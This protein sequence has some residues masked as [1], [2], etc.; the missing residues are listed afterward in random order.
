MIKIT[1]QLSY[2][3]TD[4]AHSQ[5][6]AHGVLRQIANDAICGTFAE[7][8]RLWAGKFEKPLNELSYY[9]LVQIGSHLF[10]FDLFIDESLFAV[11]PAGFQHLIGVLAGDLFKPR[12]TISKVELPE[13]MQM[14]AKSLFRQNKAYSI[15][16]IRKAFALQD[17]EPLLAFSVKPRNGLRFDV[18]QDITLEVL[19][20]GFHI[21]ELDTR[22][23]NLQPKE[24]ALLVDLS[25]RASEISKKRI[26]RFSPNLS[27]PSHL[28]VDIASQFVNAVDNGPAVIK[29]DGGL[30]GIS[31][32]QAIR[33]AFSNAAG[34][35]QRSPIITCYPLLRLQLKD[36]ISDNLLVDTLTL[37]GADIVYIGARPS[38]PSSPRELDAADP[39]S[40]KNSVIRYHKFIDRNESMPTV[41]GGIQVNQLHA[42]YELLG[43]NAAFFVGGAVSLHKD[44][45]AKGASL[46]VQI[47][48]QAVNL[49]KKW[50]NRAHYTDLGSRLIK[51]CENKYDARF[52]YISPKDLFAKYPGLTGWFTRS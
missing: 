37:S 30:D 4:D 18:L 16:E 36:K 41:A 32:C 9:E 45:V 26:T 3:P 12:V 44:G 46:C 48:N 39:G 13:S 15:S 27:V 5:N 19:K 29:I 11:H 21:V 47:I 6:D 20:A 23:L 7:Y 40:I 22:N 51:Q 33:S 52:P 50:G 10:L 28:I 31:S 34:A 25:K 35:S 14:E 49:R 43:P 17:E 2:S 1:G 38:L 8:P 24:I 42:F